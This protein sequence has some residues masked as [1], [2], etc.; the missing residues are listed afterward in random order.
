MKDLHAEYSRF[1][2]NFNYPFL[3]YSGV[4]ALWNACFAHVKIRVYKD[5]TGKCL[6]CAILAMMRSTYSDARRRAEVTHLCSLHRITYMAER[7]AY[8]DRALKAVQ[9]PEV[10]W[11]IIFDGM[12]QSHTLCPWEGNLHQAGKYLEQHIQ[13]L[14][15][16]GYSLC[17]VRDFGNF[18]SGGS[19]LAIHCLLL[20]LL[21]RYYIL[22]II[23]VCFHL[24]VHQLDT[25][26]KDI[27][28]K[29]FIFK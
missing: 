26:G 1:C 11:S 18:L 28:L 12:A 10:Y 20:A 19:N 25:K 7:Q 9:H 23:L 3:K 13:G 5:V 6:I 14:L 17:L 15:M 4:V 22:A 27:F 24:V 29:F 8:H 2:Q 16:H 21:Y